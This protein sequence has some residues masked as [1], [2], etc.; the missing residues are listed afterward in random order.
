MGIGTK[1][2]KKLLYFGC[3]AWPARFGAG[4]VAVL[5]T[6]AGCQSGS[7]K[8][9]F[10][11]GYRDIEAQ[12]LA[13]LDINRQ[14]LPIDSPEWDSALY[15]AMKPNSRDY[16]ADDFN[17][18]T[19]QVADGKASL[20]PEAYEEEP[21]TGRVIIKHSNGDPHLVAY[22]RRGRFVE[23]ATVTDETGQQ[24]TELKYD[25]RGTALK[26]QQWDANGTLVEVIDHQAGTTS[27]TPGGPGTTP[28]NPNLPAKFIEFDQVEVRGW[29]MYDK[30]EE[31][32]SYTG[33]IVAFHDSAKTKLAR[34]ESY[35]QGIPEGKSTW[36]HANGQKQFEADY[37]QGEPD[38]LATW[39][40]SD[41]SP[42]HE[43]FWQDGTLARATTWD[44]DGQENGKVL[45]GNGTLVFLHPDGTKR[46]ETIYTDGKL[47]DEHWWDETGKELPNAPSFF[48]VERPR[49]T[50]S[51]APTPSP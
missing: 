24:R 7:K 20:L 12:Y 39:W 45:S 21:Y 34:V 38:G 3:F 33:A 13:R 19:Y 25:D 23:T 9:H 6:V 37:V 42:E 40:R 50:Q 27:V 48:R 26:T 11:R 29:L 36:W 44:T 8:S 18:S 28:A 15:F 2:M 4:A 51:P 31:F 5:L 41:G 46:Q 43:A 47:T 30:S 17:S 10:S 1:L 14:A 49:I 16:Y 22:I 32:F 35:A